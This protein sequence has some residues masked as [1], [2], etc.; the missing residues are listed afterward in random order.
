MIIAAAAAP[1]FG[2]GSTSDARRGSE[3]SYRLDKHKWAVERTF[4][5]LNHFRRLATR[6]ERRLDTHHALTMLA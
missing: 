1:A 2:A 3:S 6:Y 4:A 5:W